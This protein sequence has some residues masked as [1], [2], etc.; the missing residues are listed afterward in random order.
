MCIVN[1][2]DSSVWLLEG[3]GLLTGQYFCCTEKTT[4][5]RRPEEGQALSAP[6]FLKRQAA[7]S[8]QCSRLLPTSHYMDIAGHLW[9][10]V[11]RNGSHPQ[12]GLTHVC[13]ILLVVSDNICVKTSGKTIH[14]P[15]QQKGSSELSIQQRNTVRASCSLSPKCLPEQTALWY[16]HEG[17]Q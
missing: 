10:F 6:T 15:R 3:A 9:L 14:C 2:R 16:S 7:H 11:W 1:A 4:R 13:L 8:S 12:L 5:G 17:C